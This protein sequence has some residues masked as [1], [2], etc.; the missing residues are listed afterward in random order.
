MNDGIKM[1]SIE[2][3]SV[4]GETTNRHEP[5]VVLKDKMY[6]KPT[7]NTSQRMFR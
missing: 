1:S 5:K 7:T 4:E 6:Q 3:I 2:L